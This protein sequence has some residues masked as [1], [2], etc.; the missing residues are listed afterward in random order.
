[1]SLKRRNLSPARV[2]ALDFLALI[3][4]GTLLLSL[5]ISSAEG[6]FTNPLDAGFTAVSATCVTGLV[7]FNT[8]TY[9]STFGKAVILVLIQ[10]GGLGVV[11]LGVTAALLAGKRIG[12]KQRFTMQES[13]SA[14]QMGGI[15]RMTGFILKGVAIFELAGAAL[16]S[17]RFIPLFGVWRGIWYSVF[18]SISAFC[19]AG[20]DLMGTSSPFCSLTGFVSDPVVNLVVMLLIVTG[21]IG[22]TVWDDVRK[23][24]FRAR[25]WRLQSKLVI[26]V[27]LVLIL[28]P[29]V[30]FY[31]H[32]FRGA[33]FAA[34]SPSGRVFAS[35]FQSVTL[36]TAGF[37]TVDLAAMGELEQLVMIFMMLIGGSPGGTAG[38]FKTT[39]LVILILCVVSTVRGRDDLEVFGRRIPRDAVRAA[40]ALVTVYFA[41][42]LI[43]GGVIYLSEDVPL[44]SAL[45][46]SA[47]AIGTV[48]L[49]LGITPSL[50]PLSK[51]TL[52]ILMYLGRIGGLTTIYA[53]SARQA[54]APSQFPEENVTVG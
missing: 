16:L 37:N 53:L 33:S 50:G 47:S 4:L 41:L 38:G 45:F 15:V 48:G 35:L 22:F 12:L 5:P 42:F 14:P 40:I 46:E 39:S 29:A 51:A 13:I 31:V 3:A 9:W 26:T 25:R 7:V 20:F 23:N 10:I 32:G 44:I 21:G 11:T 24:A 1:M 30:F 17:V 43:G 18:H 54:P 19:N 6:R 52:M 8:A 36:R 34:L 49:T 28:M 2:V 27:S